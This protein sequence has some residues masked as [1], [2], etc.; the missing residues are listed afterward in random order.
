VIAIAVACHAGARHVVT[1]VNDYRLALARKMG[2]RL[3]ST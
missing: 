2:L 1:D 3:P